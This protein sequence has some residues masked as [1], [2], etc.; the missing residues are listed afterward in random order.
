MMNYINITVRGK[1]A[2]AEGRA[3]VVCGNSDYAVRFDFDAE[4]SEYAVK[5]ARF[6]SEDGSYTDVQFEGEDC[7]IPILRNTRTLLVGVFAGN[8]RTTT[9]AL[10]HAVPCITDPDGTPADPTPDVY[11]QLMER[12]DK[13]EAPAAVLYTAQEL[14]DEQKATARENIGVATPDWEQSDETASDYIKN[15]PFYDDPIVVPFAST[16]TTG[17]WEIAPAAADKFFSNISSYTVR[18]NGVDYHFNTPVIM[19]FMGMDFQG[20]GGKLDDN[21]PPFMSYDIPF[22]I[23]RPKVNGSYDGTSAYVGKSMREPPE[24]IKIFRSNIK[25][26]DPKFLPANRFVVTVALNKAIWAP[27]KTFAEIKAAYDA[28]RTVV[29]SLNTIE[30]PL[31][32]ITANFAEFVLCADNHVGTI[33]IMSDDSIG[34]KT[35]YVLT[36]PSDA[37]PSAPGTAAAGE[38]TDYARADHVHPSETYLIE[39]RQNDGVYEYV[40]GSYDGLVSAA[41][42]GKTISLHVRYGSPYGPDFEPYS[43]AGFFGTPGGSPGYYRFKAVN[44]GSVDWIYIDSSSITTHTES[45]PADTSLGMTGATVGQIAKITAV[46]DSGKPTAWEAVDMPSGETKK[47]WRK[48]GH[49]EHLLPDGET[50]T[51]WTDCIIG[52][53]GQEALGCEE[54]YISVIK[55]ERAYSY[56]RVSINNGSSREARP[57]AGGAVWLRAFG[58][59]P[60]DPSTQVQYLR[61]KKSAQTYLLDPTSANTNT[62]VDIINQ[63]TISAII[64]FSFDVWGK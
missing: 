21:S 63:I 31:S 43:F 48:I 13:I 61:D 8:L 6:V 30:V 46:D 35:S 5:T 20:V 55:L 34:V 2:R 12:F 47:E 59:A 58:Q 53:E 29:A 10:I 33:M 62:T 44:A 11:A 16:P 28:G 3:R 24:D 56:I 49:Y 26:I 64:Q 18:Y 45:A 52:G 38:S 54:I 23:Y 37:A 7:A 27:D 17:A 25:Q 51:E 57:N 32:T 60:F 4:W 14:T 50:T 19:R 1:I 36:T 39:I 42:A 22:V 41:A 15:R 40:T 9:A